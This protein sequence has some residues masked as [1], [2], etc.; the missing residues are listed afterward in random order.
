MRLEFCHFFGGFDLAGHKRPNQHP[1][2]DGQNDNGKT[3]SSGNMQSLQSLEDKNQQIYDWTQ[4][5]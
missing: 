1:D 3:Q 4:K 5:Y 2:Y